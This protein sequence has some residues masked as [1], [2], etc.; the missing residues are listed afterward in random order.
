MLRTRKPLVA[1]LVALPLALAGCAGGGSGGG[2]SDDKTL[3][4]WHYESE[5]S[6]MGQAWAKAIEILA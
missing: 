4:I 3:T 1:A 6:A 5:T 2:D